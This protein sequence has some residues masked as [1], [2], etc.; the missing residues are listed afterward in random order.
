QG[1]LGDGLQS[2]A[3]CLGLLDAVCSGHFGSRRGPF[4]DFSPALVGGF[5]D[6][7]VRLAT[8]RRDPDSGCPT[9]ERHAPAF[10]RLQRLFLS[11]L[12]CAEPCPPDDMVLEFSSAWFCLG[13]LDGIMPAFW[14][15]GSD[16]AD[17]LSAAKLATTAAGIPD[18]H[19]QQAHFFHAGLSERFRGGNSA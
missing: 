10:C 18:A 16:A 14:R 15:T 6:G 11:R 13:P 9:H 4:Q 17:D 8:C 1:L 12:V 3:G 19:G 5:A 2:L 7:L